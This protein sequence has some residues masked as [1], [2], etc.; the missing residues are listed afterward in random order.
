MI[1]IEYIH[2][3][4]MVF[5]QTKKLVTIKSD[6]Y[7]ILLEPLPALNLLN[8]SDNRCLLTLRLHNYIDPYYLLL[9]IN[10]YRYSSLHLSFYNNLLQISYIIDINKLTND[11]IINNITLMETLI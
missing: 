8:I 5:E 4:I 2:K 11:N 7:D 6:K 1:A 9:K 10:T 3:L